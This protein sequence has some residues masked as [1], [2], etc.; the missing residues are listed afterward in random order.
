MTRFRPCIDLHAG[1]V[2]QIVGGTLSDTESSLRT[3]HVSQQSAGHFA[4]LYKDNGLRGAHVIMLG[5][6][7]EDAAKQALAAWPD[8]LQL[9]GGI[10]NANAQ[11][12]L[13][14]G[15]GKVGLMLYYAWPSS[16][17]L[18]W[19]FIG[20]IPCCLK[21]DAVIV[22]HRYV[23]FIPRRQILDGAAQAAIQCSTRRKGEAC[24]RS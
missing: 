21:P 6:G 18:L 11:T 12:W 14:V 10:N 20:L 5:P 13:D 16:I 23:L 1:Q 24:D 8:E 7:N 17:A 15:A 2:K 22:G 19:I 3:N 9:G 4:Q